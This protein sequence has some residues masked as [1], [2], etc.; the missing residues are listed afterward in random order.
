MVPHLLRRRQRRRFA[1][2]AISIP[3]PRATRWKSISATSP[4]GRPSRGMKPGPRNEPAT[5]RQIM[6][7][8]VPAGAHLQSVECA[9]ISRRGHAITWISRP[10]VLSLRQE[11]AALRTPGLSRTD[12]QRVSAAYVDSREIAGQFEIMATARP[13]VDLAKVERAHRRRAGALS[14]RRSDGRG[15]AARQDGAR[16]PA[17]F[18]AWSGSAGSAGPR[19]SSP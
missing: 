18:A 3:R 1:S 2:P 17:S 19:T 15:V 14:Q 6:D 9:R 7:D 8:R 12:R 10:T 13:G 5:Q 11:V 16:W 4:P